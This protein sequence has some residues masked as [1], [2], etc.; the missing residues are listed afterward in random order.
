M[1]VKS[2]SLR[3][4]GGPR[5]SGQPDLVGD[6]PKPC[7]ATTGEELTPEPVTSPW[8]FKSVAQAVR[9]PRVAHQ[10]LRGKPWGFKSLSNL[11]TCSEQGEHRV[12]VSEDR[13]DAQLHTP[14][15]ASGD[16]ITVTGA[17][18]RG[19]MINSSSRPR[20]PLVGG[21]I[22]SCRTTA[23]SICHGPSGR[24]P[25]GGPRRRQRLGPT[26]RPR[27]RRRHPSGAGAL[28]GRPI[29]WSRRA[30]RWIRRVRLTLAAA[31]TPDATGGP[32]D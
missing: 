23:T 21:A 16:N 15:V 10:A 2:W 25:S 12:D 22:R 9:F 18:V 7:T 5:G 24:L 1:L 19:H 4:L 32:T 14:S 30:T 29:G 20:N 6:V 8:G 31:I 13:H 3:P 11:S 27:R 28:L 26:A 17:V